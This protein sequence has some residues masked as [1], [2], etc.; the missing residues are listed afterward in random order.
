[1]TA[2]TAMATGRPPK[3]DATHYLV[4]VPVPN[5]RALDPSARGGEGEGEGE[6]GVEVDPKTHSWVQPIVI[7]DEDLMFGGKSLSAWYEEDRRRLSS[8]AGDEEPRGRE[9]VRRHDAAS[10]KSRPK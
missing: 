7:D 5:L 2:M 4:P 3:S 9:R 10:P 8:G 6:V 1:M